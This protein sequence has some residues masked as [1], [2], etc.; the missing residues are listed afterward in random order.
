MPRLSSFRP[1]LGGAGARK[2]LVVVLLLSLALIALVGPPLILPFG[3]SDV[4]FSGNRF[5]PMTSNPSFELNDGTWAINKSKGGVV[6]VAEGKSSSGSR[7]LYIN[8]GSNLTFVYYNN[9]QTGRIP[10]NSSIVFGFDM[11]YKGRSNGTDVSSFQA[12][13][14]ISWKG[15]NSVPLTIAVGDFSS[16]PEVNLSASTFDGVTPLGGIIMIRAVPK[17]QQWHSYELQ[18]NTQRVRKLVSTFLGLFNISVAADDELFLTAIVLHPVNMEGY[19]DDVGAFNVEPSVASVTVSKPTLLPAP[20]FVSGLWVNGTSVD[21]GS[22]WGPFSDT[23]TF[24]VEI[25]LAMGLDF[26]IAVQ[27]VGGQ[28]TQVDAY[29]TEA[30]VWI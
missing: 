30:P 27:T 5:Q 7:S 21:F 6:Y 24:R 15:L 1:S 25:P 22:S 4:S 2:F 9:S 13:L 12:I 8:D 17:D 14:V 3:I 23:F 26:R 20:W 29:V 10:L 11:L 16:P 18:L 19:I 28:R